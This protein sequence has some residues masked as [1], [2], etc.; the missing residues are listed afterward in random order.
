MRPTSWPSSSRCSASTCQPSSRPCYNGF[1]S[2]SEGSLFKSCFSPPSLAANRVIVTTPSLVW[3]A[4]YS[5]PSAPCPIAIR[6]PLAVG[7]AWSNAERRSTASSSQRTPRRR[8]LRSLTAPALFSSRWGTVPSH[9]MYIARTKRSNRA[10]AYQRPTGSC[11]SPAGSPDPARGLTR[12]H[13]P[14]R[15][16]QIGRGRPGA[17]RGV[18]SP[19]TGPDF[20]SPP[21]ERT[22]S[23]LLMRCTGPAFGRRTGTWPA[24]SRSLRRSHS[25][26]Q[27]S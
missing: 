2:T 18:R 25:Q 12:K 10:R 8:R 3:T 4:M 20:T 17:P 14:L 22:V 13:N 9:G 6:R 27:L 11:P 23:L 19:P 1:Q 21:P 7:N 15:S 26:L 16:R 5:C 24:H